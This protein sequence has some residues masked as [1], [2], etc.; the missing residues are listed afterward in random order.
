[1]A[2][3]VTLRHKSLK[4][5]DGGPAQ[6][7]VPASAARVLEKSGWKPAPKSEQPASTEGK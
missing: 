6:V 3:K 2:D 7:T 5:A 4:D 1:M